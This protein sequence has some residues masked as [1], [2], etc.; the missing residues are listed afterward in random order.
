M[1][2]HL[3]EVHYDA[4]VVGTDLASSILAAALSKAGKKVLH[5]DENEYYGGDSAS[6]ALEEVVRWAN[7]RQNTASTSGARDLSR[8]LR[9]QR[10]KFT[11]VSYAFPRYSHSLD[12]PGSS[13]PLV[14]PSELQRASRQYSI[15]L[16]PTLLPS[17]GPLIDTL[18]KSGVSRYGGFRLLEGVSVYTGDG[19]IK[20]VPSSK[21]DVF[22]DKEMSLLDK[23]KLMKFLMFATGDFESK[24]EVQGNEDTPLLSFLQNTFSLSSD[25]SFA[26]AFAIAHCT[27]PQDATLPA[28]QRMRHYLRSSG[29]Y[30]NSPFLIGHYGGPGEIAQGFCRVTAVR[31]GTYILGRRFRSLKRNTTSEG[32]PAHGAFS[33]EL[34]D[35][36]DTLHADVLITTR[37]YLPPDMLDGADD[38]SPSNRSPAAGKKLLARGIAVIDHPI[39]YAAVIP[40]TPDADQSSPSSEESTKTPQPLDTTLVVFPP[41]CLGDT[42]PLFES[43]VTALITGEGAFSCP[44]GQYVVYLCATIPS[45]SEE[46]LPTLNPESLL[47][48]YLDTLV[49]L[50]RPDSSS[51]SA[52]S[53]PLFQMFYLQRLDEPAAT[54]LTPTESSNPHPSIHVISPDPSFTSPLTETS[55][56]AATEAERVFRNIMRP[57]G[58]GTE[59]ANEEDEPLDFWPPLEEEEGGSED[60]EEW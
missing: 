34:E 23:R 5:L 55:D 47:K 41:G 22:K 2:D 59:L 3:D 18:I 44:R 24:P 40:P 48:P 15:S 54:T 13:S 26:I 27:S 30:G 29:R 21:E 20:R 43:S 51:S 9:R 10:R 12:S 8:Y 11:S 31:G 39:Q 53:P 36:P 32:A 57:E 45:A 38:N 49:A 7:D 46:T 28:L 52:P 33:I 19:V 17:T 1:P 58:A 16:S 56:W 50:P 60:V 37:D 35:I 6:L 14:L 4:V 25:V 42:R